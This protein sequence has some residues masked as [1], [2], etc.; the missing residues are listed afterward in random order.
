MSRKEAKKRPWGY[1]LKLK[2]SIQWL[3]M[4]KIKGLIV[5][6]Y[7]FETYTG[8]YRKVGNLGGHKAIT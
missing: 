3:M 7:S 5:F 8:Y 1:S 6:S 4:K 2:I